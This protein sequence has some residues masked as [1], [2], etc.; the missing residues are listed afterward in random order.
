MDLV[1]IRV[2][3]FFW[4]QNCHQTIGIKDW[5]ASRWSGFP[6]SCHHSELADSDAAYKDG[7]KTAADFICPSFEFSKRIPDK[8]S[9]F[10]AELEIV[11]SAL[12]YKKSTTKSNFIFIFSDSQSGLHA[13]LSK[14]DHP[15]VLS[16]MRLLV[17]LHT[18]HNNVIFCWLPSHIRITGNVSVYWSIR[19]WFL[20]ARM[21]HGC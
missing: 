1:A 8:A 14:W 7:D 20:A 11:V 21:G 16:I 12:R 5:E 19:T 6:S 18:I 2:N 10:T 17:F 15:T 9:I 4:T 13:L 3:L